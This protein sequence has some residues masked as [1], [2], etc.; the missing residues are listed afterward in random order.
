M[1]FRKHIEGVLVTFE[2]TLLIITPLTGQYPLCHIS[3][4]FV[5]FR[6]QSIAAYRIYPNLWITINAYEII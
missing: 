5:H 4:H 1:F 2:T 3:Y 6:L